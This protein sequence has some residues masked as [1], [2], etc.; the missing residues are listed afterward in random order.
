MATAAARPRR[1]LRTDDMFFSG[2]AVVSLI[3]VLAGFA[4]TYF[5]AG[6]FRAPLPNLLIHIHGAV[7]TL[8]SSCSLLKSASSPRGGCLCVAASACQASASLC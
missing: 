4:R 2:M 3:A 7:Y 6:V 1:S 5:L 8:W